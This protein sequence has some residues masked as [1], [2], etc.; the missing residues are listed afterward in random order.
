[1]VTITLLNVNDEDPVFEGLPYV[2]TM[3]ETNIIGDVIGTVFASDVDELEEV[4]YSTSSSECKLRV[5]DICN[6]V[7]VQQNTQP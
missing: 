7:N 3:K 5:L 2:F 6:T 4:T 1:M